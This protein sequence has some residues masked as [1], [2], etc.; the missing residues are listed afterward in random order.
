MRRSRSAALHSQERKRGATRMVLSRYVGAEVRRKGD[1]RLIT[2]SSTY[3]DDVPIAGMAYVALTR[4]PHPH[5]RIVGFD[6][7]AALAMPGV[8]AVFTGDDLARYV[9]PLSESAS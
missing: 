3:V 2:G 9:E 7:A 8:I 4:S 5:A 6:T 1:P